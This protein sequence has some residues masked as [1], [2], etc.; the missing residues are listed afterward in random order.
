MPATLLEPATVVTRETAQG[1]LAAVFRGDVLLAVTFDHADP[2]AALRA[3][4]RNVLE[5]LVVK[6][7]WGNAQA[8]HGESA[9][10]G[11]A[12]SSRPHPVVRRLEKFLTG[13]A[14]TL[15]DIKLD[16]SWCTPFQR[17]VIRAVRKIPYGQTRTYGQIAEVAGSPRAARAVGSIM[18]QNRTPLVVPCHRVVASS[19]MGGFSSRGGLRTKLRLLETESQTNAV[20]KAPRREAR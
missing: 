3:L 5:P 15:L 19:G 6:L 8:A 20:A 10:P 4:P 12:I 11:L 1:W 16:E 7:Q 17:A 13:E 14:D 9:T 18:A 2:Q